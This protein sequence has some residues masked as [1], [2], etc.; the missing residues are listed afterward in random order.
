AWGAHSP[1]LA[2]RRGFAA[3]R[4]AG[5]WGAHS[6]ALAERRGCAAT[7][8]AGAWGAH[9]PALAERR[10]CA[11]TRSAGGMGGPFEGPPHLQTLR[12]KDQPPDGVDLAVDV[13]ARALLDL[14][15]RGVRRIP[16]RAR[17]EAVVPQVRLEGGGNL[18]VQ[19]DPVHD[20]PRDR[21]RARD[22]GQVVAAPAE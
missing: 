14:G 10:G 3:T 1:A 17:A 19:F 2:E 22:V 13:S 15:W 4:S 20:R 7:R 18:R 11:A 21:P 9:S 6:P 5:A 8:S 16:E 12:R